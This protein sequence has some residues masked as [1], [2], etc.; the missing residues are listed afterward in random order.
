MDK[1][2]RSF[3]FWTCCSR[4]QKLAWLLAIVA[5]T[6]SRPLKNAEGQP[7]C[8]Y[9][10]THTRML[11]HIHTH[12][13]TPTPVYLSRR[14]MKC[15]HSDRRDPLRTR[16]HPSYFQRKHTHMNPGL[17]RIRLYIWWSQFSACVCVDSP[18]VFSGLWKCSPTY[19]NTS[20]P[21]VPL[22]SFSL[23]SVQ[24]TFLPSQ[25]LH[26]PMMNEMASFT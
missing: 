24:M 9:T 4:E 2:C 21:L 25:P 17:P 8:Q 11:V 3:F 13:H 16:L 7:N 5:V 15:D 20:V 12:T 23:I 1:S 6:L 19:D 22:P 10:Q 26:S 14:L 18:E